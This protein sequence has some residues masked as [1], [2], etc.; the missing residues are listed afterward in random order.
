M[1]YYILYKELNFFQILNPD[2][3]DGRFEFASQRDATEFLSCAAA[4]RA[5]EIILSNHGE[6]LRPDIAAYPEDLCIFM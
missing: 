2:G 6:A 1:R 3:D 5:I 4:N